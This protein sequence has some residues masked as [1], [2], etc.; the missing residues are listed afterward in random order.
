MLLSIFA[1]DSIDAIMINGYFHFHLLL[2]VYWFY[3]IVYLVKQ[4]NFEI[5]NRAKT[6][7]A[8]IIKAHI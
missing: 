3:F 4:T 2:L 1:L 7:R 6:V 8:D 5:P